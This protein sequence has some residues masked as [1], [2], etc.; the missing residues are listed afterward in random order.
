MGAA[1]HNDEARLFAAMKW[2]R[3]LVERA[4]VEA[5]ASRTYMP[6]RD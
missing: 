6:G 5:D 3:A 1:H 2:R 4:A